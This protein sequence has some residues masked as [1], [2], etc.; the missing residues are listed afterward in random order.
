MERSPIG[1]EGETEIP[2]S[3]VD[4]MGRRWHVYNFQLPHKDNPSIK[5]RLIQSEDTVGEYGKTDKAI[6]SESYIRDIIRMTGRNG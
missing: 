2:D 3:F 5:M 6:K 1:I 4:L